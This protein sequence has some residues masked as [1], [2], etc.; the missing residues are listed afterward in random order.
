ML[1]AFDTNSDQ[2][3]D[4]KEFALFVTKFTNTCGA[5][6]H[7]M[8]DFMI[9]TSVLKENSEAEQKFIASIGASDIYYWGL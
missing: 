4:P 2:Q 7:K 8:L 5:D 3:L 6:L 1:T 9:V